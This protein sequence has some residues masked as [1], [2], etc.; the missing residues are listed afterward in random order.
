MGVINDWQPLGS[1]VITWSDEEQTAASG[2]TVYTLTQGVY[3]VG[4]NMME[5]Y[6]NGLAQPKSYFTETDER[7]IT[8]AAA[9]EAGTKVRFRY[10]QIFAAENAV[11]PAQLEA[12]VTEVNELKKSVSDGKTAVAGAI[13][14]K[15]IITSAADTFATMAD[16]IG[17]ISTLATET[18]D[19]TA[20]AAQ[21]LSGKRAYVKGSPV[22][23]TMPNNGGPSTAI[24]NGSLKAGYTTGGDIA[25]LAA[26]N[27]KQGI[28]IGGIVG[29][30]K[31]LQ[32]AT[33]TVYSDYSTFSKTINVGYRPT[34]V[35]AYSHAKSDGETGDR[36]VGTA[37]DGVVKIGT[38]LYG[39][40]SP[41]RSGYPMI[42]IKDT[43]F[44]ITTRG[45]TDYTFSYIALKY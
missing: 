14:D 18:A 10:A 5:V 6:L 27:I 13:T 9:P 38:N 31:P 26:V 17:Q 32:I 39:S 35:I 2:Q 3:T 12:V 45:A 8:L 22:V 33:G 28:N 16:N 40:E 11:S 43:G 23:G 36:G 44:S 29:T 34:I 7:T 37:I 30:C 21:I 15:G 41:L 42:T 4:A 25:N 1:P 19:A 20:T 24:S